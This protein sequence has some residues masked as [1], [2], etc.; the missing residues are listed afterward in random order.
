MNE[1]IIIFLVYGDLN[2]MLAPHIAS[3]DGVRETISLF[4]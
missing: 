2:S 3:L 4:K 1:E